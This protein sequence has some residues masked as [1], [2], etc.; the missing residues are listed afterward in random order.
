M[1]VEVGPMACLLDERRRKAMSVGLVMGQLII[2][3]I[4]ELQ[5]NILYKAESLCWKRRSVR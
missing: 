3:I 5:M 2:H 4:I 1:F